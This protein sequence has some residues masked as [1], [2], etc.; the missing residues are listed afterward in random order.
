MIDIKMTKQGPQFYDNPQVFET[1]QRHRSSKE[2]LNNLLD[3]PVIQELLPDVA[4]K[5]A[6]ALGCGRGEFARELLSKGAKEVLGIDGS[7][8]MIDTALAGSKSERL[9]FV[10]ANIETYPFPKSEFDLIVSRLVLHYIED[11]QKLFLTLYDALKKKGVFIFS[12]E[13]PCLTAGPE[14]W[15]LRKKEGDHTVWQV[16]H[17]FEEGKRDVFW[18]GD[19]VRKY[20]RTVETYFSMLK[21]SGFDVETIRES[22]PSKE[23]VKDNALYAQLLR[24]PFFLFLK[25]TKK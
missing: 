9:S 13:H 14:D 15:D 25:A 19:C 1:Y 22:K 7:Q 23:W 3:L 6:L 8:N 10:K 20:H 5:V 2:S 18:M 21:R 24:L 17:Y 11:L 4:G 16:D 12:V